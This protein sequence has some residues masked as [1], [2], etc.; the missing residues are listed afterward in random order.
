MIRISA[1][2][3]LTSISRHRAKKKGLCV[4]FGVSDS[5]VKIMQKRSLASPAYRRFLVRNKRAA[6][7]AAGPG[8]ISMPEPP[9]TQMHTTASIATPTTGFE[10]TS[11]ETAKSMPLSF[12]QL[13]NVTL[14]TLGRLNVDGAVTEILKRHI[15]S[16]DHVSYEE[17]EKISDKINAFNI[18][19]MIVYTMPYKVGMVVAASA[20][21]ASFPLCFHADSVLY[22]NENFVTMDAPGAGELDT[23]LEVGSWAWN[24]MEPPLG[25]ISFVLLC[26]Q[27]V[28]G[29]MVNLG[30][31]PFTAHVKTRRA[32][33]LVEKFPQ[34][35]AELLSHF[36]QSGSFS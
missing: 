29:Q 34:Y 30:I 24:W 35:N 14:V 26:M 3:T 18:E 1:L 23:W 12:T 10:T 17:A 28:R 16:V 27:Y 11:I 8:S 22:F 36:S 19:G 7:T 21:F 33:R 5:L 32:K 6:M 31:R 25:Q 13:D 15:M 4:A 20:A 2:Q 9:A